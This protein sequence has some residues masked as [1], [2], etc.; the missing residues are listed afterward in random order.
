MSNVTR[1]PTSG[2]QRRKNR[3]GRH[4]VVCVVSGRWLQFGPV[5]RVVGGDDFVTIDVMTGWPGQTQVSKLCQ[6][7]V[8]REDLYLALE[9][10]KGVEDE[11][12]VTG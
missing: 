8:T 1:F 7:M 3:L 4:S 2:L 11:P 6:L 12:G 5:S 9:R 10:I